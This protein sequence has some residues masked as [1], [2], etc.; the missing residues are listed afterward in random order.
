MKTK[1]KLTVIA[2]L[3]TLTLSTFLKADDVIIPIISKPAV[4]E[5]G[6]QKELTAAQIA[7]LLPWAKDSKL[8]LT[9]LLDN[10]QGLPTSEKIDR[11]LDG[12][13]QV[14]GES[15]PK[16]S[17]LFMRYVLNRAIVLNDL[18]EKEMDADAVGTPD[19]KSR[20]LVL[21]IKMAIKYYDADMAKLTNNKSTAPYASFGVEYF[22]FLTELN[23]SIFDASAE[24]NIERTSLEWLQWD[25]Y[26]DLSNATYASKILKINNALK[27]FPS[28]KLTDVQ[29]INYIRQMKK[30]S[31]QLNFLTKNQN[32]DS[33]DGSMVFTSSSPNVET[34]AI[35]KGDIVIAGNTVRTVENVTDAGQAVLKEDSANYQSIARIADIQKAVSTYGNFVKGGIVFSGNT[36]RTVE[37]LGSRGAVV[38]KEDSANYRSITTV[39]A[40]S[41]TV[42]SYSKFR[43][44]D[45]V[46]YQNVIRTVEYLDD[47]GRAVLAEDSASY[48]SFVMV[49]DVSKVL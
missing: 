6:T 27:T 16:T 42:S 8:F 28:K 15:A 44:G 49:S 20:V 34:S 10:T 35:S 26:R 46:L 29:S 43:V 9:D 47:G 12:I 39:R 38:L 5:E 24:Y 23:K 32:A 2:L 33:S 11:L 45:K 7:E 3:S 41:R 40:I 31:V 21:S 18:L 30:V 19:A 4:L 36:V 13:K 48:C 14:V 22:N 25:L 1:N 17:E 37:Y